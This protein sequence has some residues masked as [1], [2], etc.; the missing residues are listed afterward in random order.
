MARKTNF[1]HLKFIIIKGYQNGYKV[2]EPAYLELSAYFRIEE[3]TLQ[4]LEPN[5]NN[6]LDSYRLIYF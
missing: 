2:V 6:K 4:M 3:L 1:I 5:F